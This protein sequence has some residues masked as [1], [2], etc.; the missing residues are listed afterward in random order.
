MLTNNKCN[1]TNTNGDAQMMQHKFPFLWFSHITH[2]MNSNP[3]HL[4]KARHST[5][6]KGQ[7]WIFTNKMLS[8]K[9]IGTKMLATNHP[10][11]W[12]KPLELFIS[13]QPKNSHTRSVLHQKLNGVDNMSIW[14]S[15]LKL[16]II[17]KLME[18]N[19]RNRENNLWTSKILV[20][21]N[22]THF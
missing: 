15:M 9:M 17:E 22:S 1:I 5:P 20:L 21:K 10:M 14:H 3:L 19:S 11:P 4:L 8:P 12:N 13:K 6:C 16:W 7:K 18:I 2:D